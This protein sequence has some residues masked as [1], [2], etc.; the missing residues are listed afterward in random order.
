MTRRVTLLLSGLL[1][2]LALTGCAALRGEPE[3]GVTAGQAWS[4]F[5]ER[6]SGTDES[7]RLRASLNYASPARSHRL[8]LAMRGD[9]VLPVRL[10]VSAGIGTPLAYWRESADGFVAFFPDQKTAFFHED[11]RQACAALG[12]QTPFSLREM[13]EALSGRLTRFVPPAYTSVSRVRGGYE[14]LFAPGGPVVSL[15]LDGQGRPVRLTG[16]AGSGDPRPW[17]VEFSDYPET[18]ETVPASAP[19]GRPATVSMWRGGAKIDDENVESAV[20]R[21]KSFE[22]SP[23]RSRPETLRLDLP[24]GTPMRRLDESC[25]LPPMPSISTGGQESS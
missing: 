22:S 2:L 9:Y 18:A 12:F 10:D 21:V 15:T 14:Y 13:A 16:F 8:L 5:R 11:G 25:P 23:A 17:I 20:L 24:A 4:A 19:I 7:F 6:P 1:V 3:I